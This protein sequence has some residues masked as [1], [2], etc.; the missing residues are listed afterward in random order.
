[1]KSFI[2]DFPQPVQDLSQQLGLLVRFCKNEIAILKIEVLLDVLVPESELPP[3]FTEVNVAEIA[4]NVFHLT[5]LYS[6]QILPVT[7]H[8]NSIAYIYIKIKYFFK[9]YLH[10]L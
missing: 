3:F 8:T 5:V 4:A 6:Y 2:R 10:G 1:V 9:H 7:F